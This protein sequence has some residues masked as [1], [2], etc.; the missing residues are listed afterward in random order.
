MTAET[1]TSVRYGQTFFS[2]RLLKWEREKMKKTV[3]MALQERK[4]QKKNDKKCLEYG[5]KWGSRKANSEETK[6][7]AF[8]TF[9]N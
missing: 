8:E 5:E 4:I 2:E 9:K 3:A 7:T 1:E 6:R